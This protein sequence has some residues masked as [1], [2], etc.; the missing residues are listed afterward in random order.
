MEI[1]EA[2]LYTCSRNHKVEVEEAEEDEEERLLARWSP[3]SAMMRAYRVISV[4]KGA[5]CG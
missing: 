1:P 5:I 4:K 3:R 2:A